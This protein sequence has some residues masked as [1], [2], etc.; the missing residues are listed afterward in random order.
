MSK[1]RKNK[2]FIQTLKSYNLYVAFR[3]LIHGRIKHQGLD[4]RNKLLIQLKQA[5]LIQDF[6]THNW[7][8]KRI[9]SFLGAVKKGL[10]KGKYFTINNAL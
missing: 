2:A 10:I 8:T 4:P 6:E 9:I 1:K 7:S 5:E 3:V